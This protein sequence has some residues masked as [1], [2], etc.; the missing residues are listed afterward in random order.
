MPRKTRPVVEVLPAETTLLGPPMNDLERI[1]RQR[2]DEVLLGTSHKRAVGDMD[3]FDR[4][5][6]S[7]YFEQWGCLRC[8]R[9][10]VPHASGG[11]CPTCNGLIANRLGAIKRAW[12][13]AHPQQQTEQDI[14]ALTSRVR[15]AERLL[16]RVRPV[17]M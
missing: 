2:V 11:Q 13:E 7:L 6:W 10:T 1:V 9:K 16:G 5:K 17:R 15:A 4:R 14:D 3:V 8:N 12:N